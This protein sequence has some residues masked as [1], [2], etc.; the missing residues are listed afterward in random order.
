[1]EIEIKA[2]LTK[3]K[4]DEL[5]LFLNEEYK[6]VNQDKITTFRFRPKDVRVRYSDKINEIVFK[7]GDPTV[8]ARDEVSVN[9]GSV[10]DCHRMIEILRMLGFKDDPSWVKVKDEFI[11]ERCGYEYTLS[12]QF[13]ENFAYILEAEIMADDASLHVP[14]LKEILRSLGCEPIEPEEFK[15]KIKDYIKNYS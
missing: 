1:M 6:K 5:K 9:L 11:V 8:H 2:L 15:E 13:I 4:Y 10:D 3:E 12:L 7:D 14:V